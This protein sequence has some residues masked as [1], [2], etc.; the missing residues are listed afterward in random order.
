[1]P[2]PQPDP[3]AGEPDPEDAVSVIDLLRQRAAVRERRYNRV[4][5][6]PRGAESRDEL[7]ILLDAWLEARIQ[8]NRELE[9]L[10]RRKKWWGWWGGGP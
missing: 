10:E 9:L 6:M 3:A 8:L 7:D 1:M 2:G 5:E 4:A